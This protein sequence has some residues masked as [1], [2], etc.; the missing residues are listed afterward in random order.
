MAT[1]AVIILPVILAPLI[2]ADMAG[3]MWIAA[4]LI[5]VAAAAHQ[6]FSA[7]IF[8]TTSDMFPKRAVSSVTGLGG[9]TGALGGM[10]MQA[11]AGEIKEVTQSY[12]IMFIIAGSVYVLAIVLF[13][14]LAPQLRRVTDQELEY[15]PMPRPVS[16]ILGAL[17]GFIVGVPL[18]FYFQDQS[19]TLNNTL[20][21]GLHPL[22]YAPHGFD[23]AQYFAA[24]VTGDIFKSLNGSTLIHTLLLVVLIA[25]LACAA[26]GAL[27]HN[28][29]FPPPLEALLRRS[30]IN[31]PK[32]VAPRR[33]PGAQ[34]SLF[35]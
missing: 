6:G 23:I 32:R 30:R 35:T 18:S 34:S 8:T 19:L 26:L 5:G 25:I 15:T 3:G 4:T 11:V 7:N 10:I 17:L 28:L 33:K 1:C 22:T 14:L 2:P 13:H 9:M 29:L 12:L 16:A 20:L 21:A 31:R 27:L 24:I